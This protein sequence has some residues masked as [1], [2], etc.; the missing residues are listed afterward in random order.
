MPPIAANSFDARIVPFYTAK[1][2]ARFVRVNPMTLAYWSKP[3]SNLNQALVNRTDGPESR[4]PFSFMNL[5]EAYVMASLRQVYGMKMRNIRRGVAWLK[6][7]YP[8]Q[9][10]PLARNELITD[11]LELFIQESELIISASR[12]GQIAIRPIISPYLNRIEWGHDGLPKAFYPYT[13]DVKGPTLV[14]IDPTIQFGQPVIRKTR[15]KTEIIASRFEAGE[16][17]TDLSK[18][19]GLDFPSIEE[20]LRCEGQRKSA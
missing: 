6:E 12:K 16:S 11:G 13:S 8:H 3:V 10:Y 15:I 7:K 5:I 19:Y 9:P 2:I 14:T 20:A 17:I 4:S 18:D 1:D